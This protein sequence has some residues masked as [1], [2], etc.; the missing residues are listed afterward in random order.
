MPRSAGVFDRLTTGLLTLGLLSMAFVMVRREFWPRKQQQSSGEPQVPEYVRDWKGL[1]GK[2][3]TIG[4]ANAPIQIVEFT[5]LQ[6][7]ACK[8]LNSALKTTK[9]KFRDKIAVTILHFPLSI[10]P[11]ALASARAATCAHRQQRLESFVDAVFGNQDS[12]GVRPWDAFR[13]DAG[14]DDSIRFS[15][16][17]KSPEVAAQVDAHVKIGSSL[18]VAATPT[19]LVN[20]WKYR[21]A[22]PVAELDELMARLLR[23]ERPKGVEEFLSSGRSASSSPAIDGSRMAAY[24]PSDLASAPQL[25]LDPSPIAVFGDGGTAQ[26][27]LT[28]V[29]DVLALSDN[30]LAGFSMIGAQLAVFAAN[31][32][33][34]RTIGRIGSGPEEF[35][36]PRN[37][38]RIAGDT[39]VLVDATNLR[40]YW[41]TA[42]GGIARTR[43]LESS[44]IPQGAFRVVGSLPNE[45][46]VISNL[47][48]YPSSPVTSPSLAPSAS[49]AVLP[50]RGVAKIVTAVKDGLVVGVETGFRGHRR[51]EW[52][53]VRFAPRAQVAVWDTVIAITTSERYV[54]ELLN[55]DGRKLGV[56]KLEHPRRNVTPAMRESQI[57]RELTASRRVPNEGQRD[58]PEL[59]R[60]IRSARFADS[61]PAVEALLV[62]SDLTLWIVDAI[63]PDDPY[64]WATGYR[65]DGTIVGR[66]RGNGDDAPVAFGRDRAIVRTLDSDGLV[67]LRAFRIVKRSGS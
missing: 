1:I 63:A 37:V 21:G 4:S 26:E 40:V 31:G 6:C 60:L 28:N 32:R 2:G 23:S 66:L 58:Q 12:L 8:T 48:I 14:I 36:S 33:F 9:S 44:D 65:L 55:A 5:D 52:E 43:R 3:Q 22:V 50:S 19:M 59:D 57:R 27:D 47:G 64:W 35:R 51:M 16:C 25:M 41:A 34:E 56:L 29:S 46:L 62:S 54:V 38:I 67:T 18:G 30:R 53:P 61:L 42:S 11:F 7:P 20:G 24:A 10:H 13:R 39:I 45:Q 15:V 17:L 49:I